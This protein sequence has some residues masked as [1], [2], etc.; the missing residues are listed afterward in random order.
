M[1]TFPNKEAYKKYS[2]SERR[3]YWGFL[4]VVIVA[5]S[6]LLA[7]KPYILPLLKMMRQ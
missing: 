6:L 4:I 2:N 1:V 7:W 5:A 3:F